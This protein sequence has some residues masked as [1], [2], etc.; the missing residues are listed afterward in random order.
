[1]VAR[2]LG[3][4]MCLP[5]GT[6]PRSPSNL[7][8]LPLPPAPS[9]RAFIPPSLVTTLAHEE[10]AVTGR[11]PSTSRPLSCH[12]I[13][14]PNT[15]ALWSNPDTSILCSP[16][17]PQPG[18]RVP[19]LT[20]SCQPSLLLLLSAVGITAQ[21]MNMSSSFTKD[22]VQPPNAPRP[23]HARVFPG[24]PTKAIT[25]PLGFKYFIPDATV[26]DPG[27]PNI[28]GLSISGPSGPHESQVELIHR[29]AP[30]PWSWWVTPDVTRSLV[31]M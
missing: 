16:S 12:H 13:S 18:F 10:S 3:S 24:I 14:W 6:L 21:N 11:S 20:R 8:I 26:V 1:M 5:P 30:T 29:V 15:S 31:D 27:L 23:H 28:Q 2:C 7:P 9:S 22:Q 25:P 17:D 4:A 19:S